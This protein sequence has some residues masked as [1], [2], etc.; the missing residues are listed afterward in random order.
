M[1]ENQDLSEMAT[2]RR[3]H[4]AMNSRDL[5]AI[6]KAIDETV[7]PDVRFHAPVP[8]G[9]TGREALKQIWTGLLEAFPDIHVAVE[10]TL[11]EGDR[12]VA[13]NTVTGTNSG[14]YMGRPPTGKS[15]S[16]SEIFIFRMADGRI[17]EVWGVVDVL[18]QW[19][20]LGMIPL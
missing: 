20:Q 3:F 11:S 15:V 19:R 12:I 6:L 5:A 18:S 16:Y 17:A 9:A 2:L 14:R 8:V 7:A 13:R 4:D 10:D 1:P